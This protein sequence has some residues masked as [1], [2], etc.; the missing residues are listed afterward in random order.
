MAEFTTHAPGTFCWPELST[1]DPTGAAAFYQGLLGWTVNEIPIGPSETYRMFQLRGLDVAA[2]AG[3]PA[4]ERQQG[5]PPHW[6][7]YVSVASADAAANRA[8]ELGA[9]ILA[10]AFDVMDAGRMAVL[11]DPTGA[12]FS[13][14][15]PKRHIGVR[16]LRE[17]GALGWSELVTNDTD[18]AES[19]Y[20]RLFGWTSKKGQVDAGYTEFYVGAVAEAGMMKIDPKWGTMPPNWSPY[21]EVTDCDAAAAKVKALGGQVMVSPTDIANVG[22]FAVVADPQGAMFSM[23]RITAH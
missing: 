3:L 10:P 7:M 8:Q 2:A 6:N 16:V 14:W 4:D 1:T 18:R 12:V 20:T 17:P 21:F 23:I 13:L 19:F 11:Q 15:Q 5:V 22:R 9:K